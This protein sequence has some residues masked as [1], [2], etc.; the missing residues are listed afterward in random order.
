V[1]PIKVHY[2]TECSFFA[3]CESMLANFFNSDEFHKS[4]E[5]SFSYVYSAQYENGFKSRVLRPLTVYPLNFFDLSIENQSLKNLPIF[6]RRFLAKISRVIFTIPIFIYEIYFL[7]KLFSKINPDILHINNGGYPAAL[8]ARAATIAAR[9]ANIKCVVMVVNNM[10]SNYRSCNRWL[11][12]PI[13]RIVA[14]C[15]NLFITGSKAASFQLAAVLDLPEHKVLA[16]HNGVAIRESRKSSFNS[17]RR[18]ELKNF[19]GIIFGIVALLVPRKGHKVLLSAI[20]E[21]VRGSNLSSDNF[22]V[23]IEGDGPMYQELVDFVALNNLS[24][25]V[26]FVGVQENIHDFMADLDVLILPSIHSEDFPNV[27][28]EAM[29]LGVPTIATRLA[30]IPEQIIHGKTGFIVDINN[31]SQLADAMKYFIVNNRDLKVMG[32]AS[33]IQFSKNFTIEIALENY[34]KIYKKLLK[35]ASC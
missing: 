14:R 30:G 18:T 31:P 7:H 26:T 34:N 23:L 21:L 35:S 28:I 29:A 5:I 1:R 22:L 4:Y 9:F 15:V 25:W 16:V 19:K 27:I 10:A 20:L 13:D 33:F 3:G 24:C 17:F 32:Q 8:S 12:Y 2:H 6:L 11:D